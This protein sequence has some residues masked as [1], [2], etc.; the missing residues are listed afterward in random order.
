MDYL[1]TLPAIYWA[2][3]TVGILIAIWA[4]KMV[5]ALIQA[6]FKAVVFI[7]AICVFVLMCWAGF[8]VVESFF[9]IEKDASAFVLGK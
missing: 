5:W 2:A 8:R 6:T 3:I 1:F 7:V 9:I 4:L